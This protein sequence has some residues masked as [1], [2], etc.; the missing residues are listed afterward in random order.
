MANRHGVSDFIAT[1][2]R[3]LTQMGRSVVKAGIDLLIRAPAIGDQRYDARLK[4]SVRENGSR[5]HA[6][7][8]RLFLNRSRARLPGSAAPQP[9]LSRLRRLVQQQQLRPSRRCRP[10]AARSSTP[11]GVSVANPTKLIDFALI[12]WGWPDLDLDLGSR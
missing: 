2:I 1:N 6:R 12:T 5:G 7:R 3:D 10:K 4:R 11:A 9:L 8:R